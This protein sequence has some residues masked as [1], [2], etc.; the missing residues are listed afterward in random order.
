MVHQWIVYFKKLRKICFF[1]VY[2]TTTR[3][4]LTGNKLTG[5]VRVEEA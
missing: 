1:N 4:K 5:S 2:D 3:R